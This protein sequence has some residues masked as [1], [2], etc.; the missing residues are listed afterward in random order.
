MWVPRYCPGER[1]QRA[2]SDTECRGQRGRPGV[3]EV[4]TIEELKALQDVEVGEGHK[5]RK[6][7]AVKH[8]A[9]KLM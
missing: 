9:Y 8:V 5:S 1:I 2:C 3:K 7:S 6:R 4:T